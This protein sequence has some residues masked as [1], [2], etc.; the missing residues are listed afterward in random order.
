MPVGRNKYH[1]WLWLWADHTA[2]A[3]RVPSHRDVA[4]RRSNDFLTNDEKHALEGKIGLAL[5][6]AVAR[7]PL[8]E[9]RSHVTD[10]LWL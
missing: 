1:W 8:A 7:Y 9:G 6:K 4:Q 3:I 2:P 5:V 10:D